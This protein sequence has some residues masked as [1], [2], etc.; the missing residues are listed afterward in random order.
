[1]RSDPLAAS[2]ALV[3]APA[4]KTLGLKFRES[5][6]P[7]EFLIVDTVPSIGPKS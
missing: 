4:L 1:M 6:E 2:S 7:V 3:L 5:R